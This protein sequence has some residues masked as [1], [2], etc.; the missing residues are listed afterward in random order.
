MVPQYV[1]KAAEK[2]RSAYDQISPKF[3]A[4]EG[5]VTAARRTISKAAK[6]TTLNTR[7]QDVLYHILSCDPFA[8]WLNDPERTV[9]LA[10]LTQLLEAFS[11]TPIPDYPGLSRGA[12]RT[13]K[14][15]S[16]K[17]SWQW[18]NSFYHTFISLI[19]DLGLNDPE[20][21]DEIYPSDMMPVM[22]VHQAKGLEFPFVFVARLDEHAEADAPHVME[23]QFRE[24][25]ENPLANLPSAEERAKQDLIRFFFV[26]YSRARYA[27]I[28]LARND[29]IMPGES[30]EEFLSFGGRDLKWLNKYVSF[31]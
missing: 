24:F 19:C 21:P 25:R 11:S 29:K 4:L 28:L 9:R 26:A 30:D 1:Q 15:E 13:S 5:Y 16:G 7:L 12:L 18:R 2:W 8:G 6:A 22:T 31:L 17:I 20:D 3:K 10:Q 14:A 27:L 23:E